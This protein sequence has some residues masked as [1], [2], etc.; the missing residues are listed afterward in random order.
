MS[1]SAGASDGTS[2]PRRRAWEI[3]EALRRARREHP[4]SVPSLPFAADPDV[5]RELREILE[6]EETVR[7]G[8][9]GARV[10]ESLEDVVAPRRLG[11]FEVG[12]RLGSGGFADVFLAW[13]PRLERQVAI[14]LFRRKARDRDA[15]RDFQREVRAVSDLR[16]PHVVP[17]FDS[18]EGGGRPFY[19]MFPYSGGTWR[20]RGARFPFRGR[21]EKLEQIADALGYAHS[22]GIVHLDVKPS[23]ILLE[24]DGTPRI[25]DFGLALRGASSDAPGEAPTGGTLPYMAPERL[26]SGREAPDPRSDVFSLGV[27]L[28]ESV[29]GHRPF[30]GGSDEEIRTAILEGRP[31]APHRLSHDVDRD[32]SAICMKAISPDPSLRYA[33]VSEF[34]EDLRE[35]LDG[36]PVKARPLG[37]I[38]R[39]AKWA[40]RDPWRAAGVAAASLVPLV[41]AGRFG[42]SEVHRRAAG[43]ALGVFRERFG[44]LRQVQAELPS[45]TS[46]LERYVEEE[47]RGELAGEELEILPLRIQCEEALFRAGDA[48]DS[49]RRLRFPFGDSLQSL[50]VEIC[51][52][53]AEL[54]AI[55]GLEGEARYYV[56]RADKARGE[57]ADDSSRRAAIRFL[58]KPLDA[59]VYL[60]RYERYETLR[61]NRIP[62]LVPVPVS[63]TGASVF[64]GSSEFVPGDPCLVVDD[65]HD[66]SP[67]QAAGLRKGDLVVRIGK[68]AAGRGLFV[69]SVL[70]GSPADRAGVRPYDRIVEIDGRRITGEY[71]WETIQRPAADDPEPALEVRIAGQDGSEFRFEVPYPVDTGP[72]IRPHRLAPTEAWLLDHGSTP[73]SLAGAPTLEALVGL[74][75]AEPRV[76]LAVP[77]EEDLT[78]MCVGAGRLVEVLLPAGVSP[79]VSTD[80]SAYP[81]ILSRE[82]RMSP[83]SAAS[84]LP[85]SYLVFVRA[86]GSEDLRKPFA[87][88]DSRSLEIMIRL[89]PKDSIPEGFVHVDGG[90]FKFQGDAGVAAYAL[91]L[92]MVEEESFFIQR[93]EV[94][95][96]EWMEF[97]N[98]PESLRRHGATPVPRDRNGPWHVERGEGG[99]FLIPKQSCSESPAVGMADGNVAAFV[100]WKNSSA[101]SAG[102]E[103]ALPTTTQWEKAARGVDG[104]WYPWG[105]RFDHG[106]TNGLYGRSRDDNIFFLERRGGFPTDESPFG[107]R[108]L[109]GG[110]VEFNAP[111]DT[112]PSGWIPLRGGSW[113]TSSRTYFRAASR[114]VLGGDLPTHGFRL[115]ARRR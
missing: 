25:S 12:R 68:F 94:S 73:A 58:A 110:A 6:A 91:P 21:V 99:R 80:V 13:D 103:Y 31:Q 102:W 65:L 47:R 37:P 30:V 40:R 88:E 4:E 29:A 34:A 11:R 111:D 107:V 60:F 22:K 27:V 26:G 90:P 96:A 17:V 78:V 14:K 49:A 24:G 19:V 66:T 63:A 35:Y 114:A 38:R 45:I 18:G 101:R 115:V 53:R 70:P 1:G 83:E 72:W 84:L 77:P 97:V 109:A 112:L 81:L 71:D 36:R 105:N 89:L 87:V 3:Y 67:L 75:P 59:E 46:Q 95:M 113:V 79:G 32:L 64:Q 100:E 44:E 104:R 2:E 56:E 98:D 76:L 106:L 86:P 48:F 61:K 51:S 28:Y 5:A 8:F 15:E 16:H 50:L 62:R 42:L 23:N 82:N 69:R 39:V 10:E 33:T 55:F 57:S 7:A 9:P 85:G 54:A 92:E 43:R 93:L 108:D 41:V 52:G 20:E 74:A